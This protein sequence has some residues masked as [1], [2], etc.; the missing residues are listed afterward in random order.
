VTAAAVERLP[1]PL[2]VE[3]AVAIDNPSRTLAVRLTENAGG[4]ESHLWRQAHGALLREQDSSWRG[5]TSVVWCS[6]PGQRDITAATA[7][8][9]QMLLARF[10]P[11]E[12]VYTELVGRPRL[13]AIVTIDRELCRFLTVKFLNR[14]V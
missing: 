6:A 4:Y 2:A 10:R 12:S 13:Y 9:F 7:G 3:G 5:A 11:G 8:D 14:P 1:T